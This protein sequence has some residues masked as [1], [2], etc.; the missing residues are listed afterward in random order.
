[1]RAVASFFIRS[2]PVPA[3]TQAQTAVLWL[4]MREIRNT[5]IN[6]DM[7][8]GKKRD[9]TRLCRTLRLLFV[10][11]LLITVSGGCAETTETDRKTAD[12]SQNISG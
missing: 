9:R 7:N 4:M 3:L 10:L 12:G 8:A 6:K 11:L 1:M 2:G 5:G